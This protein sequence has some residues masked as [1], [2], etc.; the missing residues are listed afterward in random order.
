M[1]LSLRRAVTTVAVA[2]GLTLAAAGPAAAQQITVRDARGDVQ[3]SPME[4]DHA[5]EPAPQVA[6]GDVVRTVLRHNKARVVVRVKFADLKR[7]GA[8]AGHVVR[9]ATNER[10]RRDV[11]VS[12]G[13]RMWRGEATMQRP[14]GQPVRCDVSHAINY[15]TNVIF[16]S[17]PRS[18][19][20]NP[21]WVRLGH[22]SFWLGGGKFF[23]DDA[24]LAHEVREDV[25]L[26]PRLRRG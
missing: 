10:M 19:V 16:V 26:S 15:D 14:N 9:I 22:G 8:M 7:K 2:A 25:A 5:H 24:Q 21:R 12:A 18:C 1:T 13:P 6:N 17:V 23:A 11:V 3:A 4:D 20:S